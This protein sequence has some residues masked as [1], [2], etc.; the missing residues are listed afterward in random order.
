VHWTILVVDE[1]GGRKQVLVIK[2]F[3]WNE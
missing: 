3:I 1:A 2:I